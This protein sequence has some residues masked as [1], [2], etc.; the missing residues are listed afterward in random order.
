MPLLP[1]LRRA[2]A[3]TATSLALLLAGAASP[4]RAAGQTVP[5][6][7][8][9]VGGFVAGTYTTTAV[10]VTK[11]RFGRFLF[12]VDDALTLTP[13]ILPMVAGPVAG[14]WLGAESK[15][16]LGRAMGW[17]AVGFL[18]GAALGVGVGHLIW[19]DQ[20]GR[21]AGAIIGSAAGMLTGAVLGALD[22]LGDD[23]AEPAMVPLL[24]VRIPLGGR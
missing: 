18:G 3:A 4:G 1:I 5:A 9:T 20:E 6:I 10:Y 15:V 8:G 16:A 2:A 23:E 14:G 13:E 7:L 22:G 12:S 19:R 11:A 21:W 24:S 17:G